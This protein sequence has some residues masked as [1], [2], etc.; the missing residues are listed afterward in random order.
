MLRIA[1]KN[2]PFL[3]QEG[4]VLDARRACS[5]TQ[6]GVFLLRPQPLSQLREG[7]FTEKDRQ[8]RTHS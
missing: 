5:R 4:H 8:E 3:P 7:T 6:K 2:M 1:F